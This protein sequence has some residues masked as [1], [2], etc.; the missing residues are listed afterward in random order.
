MD[1]RKKRM[2]FAIFIIFAFSGSSLAF[3]FD[4]AFNMATDQAPQ[5]K[6]DE[7]NGPLSDSEEA[8]YLQQNYLIV[9]Y[10]YSSN[11]PDCARAEDAIAGLRGEVGPILLEKVPVEQYGNETESFGV[12]VIPSVYL[13]G[14]STYL[15]SGAPTYDELFTKACQ[16]FFEPPSAC[17]I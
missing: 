11:C 4:S 14:S 10:F 3:A 13:K 1:Q 17:P 2:I 12:T 8:P 9:R 16:L 15:F 7:V 6:P 5:K